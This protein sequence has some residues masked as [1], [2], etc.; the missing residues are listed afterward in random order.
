MSKPIFI[1]RCPYMQDTNMGEVVNIIKKNMEQECPD[2]H[3]LTFTKDTYTDFSFEVHAVKEEEEPLDTEAIM[4]LLTD[5]V[6]Q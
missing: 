5:D 4:K 3:V 2:Y 1:I 6:W